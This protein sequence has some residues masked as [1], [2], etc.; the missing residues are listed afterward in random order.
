MYNIIF[1]EHFLNMF[2]KRIFGT[3]HWCCLTYPHYGNRRH[4]LV[5]KCICDCIFIIWKIKFLRCRV[6]NKE[7]LD[8]GLMLKVMSDIFSYIATE[9]KSLTELSMKI[10]SSSPL[11]PCHHRFSNQCC[12]LLIAKFKIFRWQWKSPSR[13]LCLKCAVFNTY[14]Q[15]WESRGLNF[16]YQVC[17]TYSHAPSHFCV[18]VITGT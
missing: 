13:S 17:V 18:P 8:C 9:I 4:N 11:F 6:E 2:S 7:T 15:D 14:F 16:S 5:A 3:C 10:R 12:I 1:W